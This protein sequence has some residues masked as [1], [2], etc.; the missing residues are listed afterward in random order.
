M[1]RLKQDIRYALRMLWKSPGFTAVTVVILALG[2]GANTAI[3]SLMNQVLL[4]ALPVKRPDELVILSSPGPKQ[5]HVSSDTNDNGAGSF[6][7]L[8]YK[9]LREH[10]EVFSGLLARFPIAIS[11]SFQGQTERGD[12][13]LVSGN[14]FEVLGVRP[15]LGRTFT[16][17]DDHTPGAH[18]LVVLSHDFWA[19]RFGADPLILNQTI[20]INGQ[21]MT[22]IGVAE[23]G[24]DGIQLG[25]HP[26]VFIPITMK[27]LMTPTWDGLSDR[28]D[29]WIN[30]LGRLVPGVSR[31]QAEVGLEPLYRSLLQTE[32]P[33]QQ[34][35]PHRLE[36]FLARKI[37]LED[38]SQGRLILQADT[39]EPLMILMAMV[40]LVLLI[41][42]ANVASLLIARGAAR[43]KE[44]AIRQALGAGHWP[45]VRQLLVESLSLS[46][47]GGLLGMLVALWTLFG[48]K[49]W[50]PESEGLGGVSVEL[51]YV[52]LAFNFGLAV[53]AGLV[54]GLA[55]AFKSTRTDL[56]SALKDQGAT[57]SVGKSHARFRKGLVVAEIA[58]TVVLLVGAG[59]FARSLYNLRHLDVGIRTERLM[60]FSIAPDLSGYTPAR[61][62]ALFNRLE[63]NLAALPGV[64][65]VG[66]AQLALFSGNN[67]GSNVTIE[68]YTP[69]EGES[70]QV[71]RNDVGPGYFAAVG[72]PLLAGRE[73]TKK[74]TSASQK[75][76]IINETMARQYFGDTDPVGRRMRYGGGNRPLDIEIV[77]VVKDS[78]HTS[79]RREVS[80]FVY[81][82]YTQNPNL[83]ELTF[84]VRT[85]LEPES[86][87]NT[88]RGQVSGLDANLPVYDLR[89]LTQQIEQ[90]IFGDRLMA[91]LSA[92]FG[93]LAALLAAIGIYGVMAYSVT[94]RTQEIGIRM[95]LGARQSDVLKLIV[96]QGLTLIAA[97][98]GLGLVASF[99]VTRL[100]ASLLYG[101][102]A[103]DPVTFVVVTVLLVGIALLACF[104][105]ARRASKVDPII[106]LRYE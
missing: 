103:T 93:V 16:L 78:R 3:F 60:A 91:V 99:A 80:N 1:G 49:R 82:P 102:A 9:D 84:Y 4:S 90:S 63:E 31:E 56:V 21:A 89:T 95:A 66:C 98:A 88:L 14:Y 69:A 57:T 10:N 55:P 47:L 44:I 5:G 96:G 75:V 48:L 87:A 62:I 36:Q 106:A 12:G 85:T 42:C 45:L 11:M 32:A 64:E 79:V 30:V 104:V 97:G 35:P 38:G 25:Q 7:Y 73:F 29:Y 68:G 81:N 37:M 46:L 33:L 58:L 27:A 77:G 43:Q 83:G 92:V 101:V 50:I 20:N 52:M 18:P 72:V 94:Q 15:A 19:R 17:E 13:E 40:G 41:A 67:R 26:D 28:K 8:M 39:R 23:A 24:F 54:F 105:P 86:L 34:M 76:A 2:I 51:D 59:L 100:I 22:V 70:M 65:A 6:S 71:L 53:L 61:A 74:D